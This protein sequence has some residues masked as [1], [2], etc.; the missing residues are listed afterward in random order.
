LATIENS[1][2]TQ[3][4]ARILMM[5][6]TPGETYQYTVDQNIKCL[7]SIRKKF[8]YLSVK[9]LVPFPG[10]SIWNNPEQFGVSIKTRDFS[11]YNM[12]MYQL[13]KNGKKK[14][15]EES[16]LR[17]HN[18][19]ER[20]QKENLIRMTKYTETLPETQRG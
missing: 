2:K 16:V 3:I 10:T 9:P 11:Q 4:G 5:I 13:G 1:Y 19:T 7:E 17:I 20:Q 8:V 12:W 15:N 14:C 6:N 18:M